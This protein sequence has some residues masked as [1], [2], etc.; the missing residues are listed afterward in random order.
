MEKDK[1]TKEMLHK[2]KNG[3]EEISSHTSW[4]NVQTQNLDEKLDKIIELLMEIKEKY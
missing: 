1:E 3:I 2:I 4:I